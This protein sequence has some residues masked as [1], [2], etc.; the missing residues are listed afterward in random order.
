LPPRHPCGHR[1]EPPTANSVAPGNG[2]RAGAACRIGRRWLIWSLGGAGLLAAALVT[3][4]VAGWLGRRPLPDSDPFPLTPISSSAFL[5]TR[6]N[7]GFVGSD[8]CRACHGSHALSYGRTGMG[9]SMADLD[10]AHEPPDGAF[11][12]PASKRRYQI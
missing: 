5:N 6:P 1:M 3:A 7:V 2:A 4:A 11:D 8:A 9:R 10:P 12:H